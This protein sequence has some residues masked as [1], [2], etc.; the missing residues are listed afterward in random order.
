MLVADTPRVMI[1]AAALAV[2]KAPQPVRERV[3]ARSVRYSRLEVDA[4]GF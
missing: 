4:H 3:G 2:A 1:R